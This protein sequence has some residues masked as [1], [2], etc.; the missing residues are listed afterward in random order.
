MTVE[1]LNEV[2]G[3]S[4]NE[5]W[6]LLSPSDA[7]YLPPV[8]FGYFPIDRHG[9]VA[10]VK[11]EFPGLA[12]LVRDGKVEVE[13]YGV[14]APGD[15]LDVWHVHMQT[16]LCELNVRI[17]GSPEGWIESAMHRFAVTF[18]TDDETETV[19]LL[20]GEMQ[21]FGKLG[22]HL[23]SAEVAKMDHSWRVGRNDPCSCGSGRK[24]KKCHGR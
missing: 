2:A 4:A 20:S 9:S 23:P 22:I 6:E 17:V 10:E 7:V 5:V 19:Y 15:G 8:S 13:R 21:R 12:Q 16:N 11:I 3:L 24:Y 14:D 18:M 1:A